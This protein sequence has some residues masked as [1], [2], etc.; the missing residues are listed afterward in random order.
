MKIK[1]GLITLYRAQK[2]PRD[3]MNDQRPGV[4]AQFS[5]RSDGFYR[6]SITHF[7]ADDKYPEIGAA[8]QRL[9]E[10]VTQQLEA[11]EF[12]PQQQGGENEQ[13]E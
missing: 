8:H 4:L 3:W 9:R 13:A 12:K 7:F 11:M 1:L 10:L 6:P 2:P 5:V